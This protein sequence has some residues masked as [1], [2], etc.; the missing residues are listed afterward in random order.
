MIYKDSEH[1][2]FFNRHRV[3]KVLHK[4]LKYN[5][6]DIHCS[7]TTILPF[8]HFSIKTIKILLNSNSKLIVP[9]KLAKLILRQIGF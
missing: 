6:K 2:S 1:I 4:S 5:V 7:E 8:P 3:L 9:L